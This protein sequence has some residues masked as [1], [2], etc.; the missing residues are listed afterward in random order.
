MGSIPIVESNAGLD[1]TYASLPVLVISNYSV[2][3]PQLLHKAYPCFLAH[4]HE[5]KYKHLTRIYWQYL[6]KRAVDSGRIDH[7]ERNYPFKNKFCDFSSY[8]D[9]EG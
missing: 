6:I 3:T 7:V 2:L 5:F 1:R 4:A 8:K 9:Q